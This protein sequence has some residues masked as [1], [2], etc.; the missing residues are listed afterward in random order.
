VL[1]FLRELLFNTKDAVVQIVA[2]LGPWAYGALFLVIFCE[3]GLVVTPFLP[4]DSLIFAAGAVAAQ[5]GFKVVPLYFMLV[6]AAIIGDNVNY[7]FGHTLGPAVLKRDSRFLKKK[8]LDRT[9]VFFEKY[10]GKAVILARFTPIVRTFMPFL[11]GVGAMRY[12]K[13]L[14]LDV[15]GGFAWPAIFLFAGYFFGGLEIV[16]KRFSLVIIAIVLVSV[17][18]ATFEYVRHK[19]ASRRAVAEEG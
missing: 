14:V 19:L 1:G 13:F 8:Y 18:P 9:H 7:A 3:T 5:G 11:A 17:A 12:R 4:G 6:A 2:T 10:G 16:E 15:I